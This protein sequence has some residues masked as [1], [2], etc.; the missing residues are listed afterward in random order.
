M[1]ASSYILH[2][3]NSRSHPSLHC[4]ISTCLPGSVKTCRPKVKPWRRLMASFWGG[5]VSLE[6]AIWMSDSVVMCSS[7]TCTCGKA[8]CLES[9]WGI[10]WRRLLASVCFQF[11]PLLYNRSLKFCRAS[12]TVPS[13]NMLLMMPTRVQTTALQTGENHMLLRL[14][15][16]R[17][18]EVLAQMP[19]L[20][21]S[22]ISLGQ[23]FRLIVCVQHQ[24]RRREWA[25]VDTC[26]AWYP[27]RQADRF[28]S[29]LAFQ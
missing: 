20:N 12:V 10:Q 17:V 6:A 21:A 19:A 24:L 7:K 3:Q 29:Y 23:I 25:S 28:K 15:P 2:R 1:R 8:M 4:G 14:K 11:V 13:T 16:A 9:F 18:L 27:C 26:V 5:N 22:Q